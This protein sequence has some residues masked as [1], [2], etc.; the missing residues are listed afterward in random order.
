MGIVQ[1]DSLKGMILSYLGMGLG[2]LNKGVLFLMILST[3]EIGLISVLTLVAFLFARFA[4]LG[5]SFSVWRFFPFFR[6]AEKKHNGF[7][8]L[9][10]AT[11][12][13]GLVVFTLLALLLRGQVENVYIERSPLF[14]DYY[15]WFL[16]IGISYSFYLFFESYLKALYVTVISVFAWE[17]AVRATVT[18]LLI[19]LF[20]DLISF[21]FFV[22]LYSVGYAIA[23]F[24]LLFKLYRMGEINMSFSEIKISRRFRRIVF[25]FSAFNFVNTIAASVVASLDVLMIS[26]ALGLEDVGVFSTVVFLTSP[27]MVPYQSLMRVTYPIIA[28]HWKHSKLKEIKE[29]YTKSSSL[30]L[31]MGMGLFLVVWL[32]IDFLFSFVKPEF[33]EGI[34]VFFF[35]MIGRL[36]EMY[37][38]LNG[39][40]FALSK[41][42]KFDIFFTIFL[43]GAVF[44]MNWFLIPSWGIAGA[45]VGTSVA[46]IVYN[47]GRLLMVWYFFKLHPFERNQFIVIGLGL[48]TLFIG[49]LCVDLF[50]SKWLQMVFNMLICLVVFVAPIYIF[51]LE[52]ESI[53]FVKKL[54]RRIVKK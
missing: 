53:S 12:C 5:I 17:I 39:G 26:Y 11:V 37:C 24:I 8:P 46:L 21:H 27:L 43:V 30:S 4:T 44:L 19:L 25:N 49:S 9:M 34:W 18:L 33:Q 2:Y 3:A 28:D 36:V 20:T 42:Y 1:K 22:V 32:N 10:L 14:I 35:L 6:N 50:E 48:A 54:M 15:Y 41:K 7:F 45:A 13:I 52:K 29:L 40:I 31:V 38:G 51:S 47:I 23:P 16:P